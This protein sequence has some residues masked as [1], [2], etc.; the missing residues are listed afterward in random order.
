[1]AN[2]KAKTAL[3]R[4]I[5]ALLHWIGHGREPLDLSGLDLSGQDLRWTN[6][7]GA[8]LAG[9]NFQRSLLTGC[10]FGP[11]MFRKDPP[12]VS[13]GETPVNLEATDFSGAILLA[14][15]FNYPNI[16]EAVFEDSYLGL[17]NFRL[18]ILLTTT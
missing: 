14:A 7:A 1:M 8:N 3:S 5:D 2:S 16:A 12:H 4:G 10:Y 18:L 17:A 13:V 6:F 9:V 15:T 11:G